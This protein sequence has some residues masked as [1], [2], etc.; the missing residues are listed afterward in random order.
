[1][2]FAERAGESQQILRSL[3]TTCGMRARQELPERWLRYLRSHRELDAASQTWDARLFAQLAEQSQATD[4][5]SFLAG[6]K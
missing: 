5:G 2:F 3:T 4:I 6:L 1:M